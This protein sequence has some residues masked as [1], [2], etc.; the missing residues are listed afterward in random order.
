VKAL[1][2]YQPWATLIIEG[3]KPYE[4]RHWSFADRFPS[5]VGQRIA[6]H[7]SARTVKPDEVRDIVARIEEGHSA[8]DSTKARP[9]LDKIA[10]AHSSRLASMLPLSAVLGTA[11]LH[12]P[13]KPLEI[14]RGKVN[15]S[16]RIDHSVWAWPLTDIVR[17]DVPV[18]YRG[19]QGFWNFPEALAA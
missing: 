16:D 12:K 19:A 14:F 3:A 4:F 10:A 11:I 9:L 7:A 17:F 15:D 2:I 5:L 1:T 6:I 8:L 13:R 18:P